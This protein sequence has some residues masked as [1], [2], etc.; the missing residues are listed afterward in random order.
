VPL[1]VTPEYLAAEGLSPAFV[2]YMDNFKGFVA[3]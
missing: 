2:T 3:A 1:P